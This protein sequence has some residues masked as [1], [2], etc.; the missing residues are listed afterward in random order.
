MRRTAGLFLWLWILVSGGAAQK[1]PPAAADPFIAAID[2][3]RRSS[4]AMDCLSVSGEE[5]KMLKRIGSAFL[6]SE[7]GDFLTA[8]HVVAEMQKSDSSCPRAARLD[9]PARRRSTRLYRIPAGKLAIR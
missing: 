1:A 2:T 5:A 8:A 4:G 3:I 6:I 9:H 7:S